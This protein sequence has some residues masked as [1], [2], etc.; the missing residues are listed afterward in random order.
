[1]LPFIY[2]FF[3]LHIIDVDIHKTHNNTLWIHAHKSYPCE[4]IKKTELTDLRI[5][6]VVTG[7]LL[8]TR[9]SHTNK[10]IAPLINSTIS[11][12]K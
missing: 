12:E 10:R 3:K 8:S 1:M 7:S 11:I 9:T 2:L 6:K 5:D 4:H